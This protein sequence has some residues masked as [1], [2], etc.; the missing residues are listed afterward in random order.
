MG[1]NQLQ[2]SPRVKLFSLN[3]S[4]NV[5]MDQKDWYPAYPQNLPKYIHRG[6]FGR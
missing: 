6:N 3:M 5:I 1:M 4:P 2:N